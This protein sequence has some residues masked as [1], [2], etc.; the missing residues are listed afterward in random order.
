MDN[1]LLEGDHA[2]RLFVEDTTIKVQTNNPNLEEYREAA[3]RVDIDQSKCTYES[4]NPA[5]DVKGTSSVDFAMMIIVLKPV[6]LPRN[7]HW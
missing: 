6:Y 4:C 7:V 2:L 3:Q 5:H 1:N